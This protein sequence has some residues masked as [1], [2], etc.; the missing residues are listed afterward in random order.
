MAPESRSIPETVKYI[1]YKRTVRTPVSDRTI[2][3][4]IKIKFQFWSS[5][6]EFIKKIIFKLNIWCICVI[7]THIFTIYIYTLFHIFVFSTKY[8]SLIG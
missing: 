4:K 7:E 8:Y 1:N 3:N 2:Y 6:L 5:K